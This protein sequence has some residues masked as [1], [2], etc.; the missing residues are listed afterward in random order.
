MNTMSATSNKD[1]NESNGDEGGPTELAKLRQEYSTATLDDTEMSQDPFVV[2]Q[3]WL[4][5]ALRAK[6]HEPNAMCLAT[7]DK[8]TGMP[9]A[10][11]VLLKGF[12]P[13]GGFVWYTNYQSH[14]GMQLEANPQAALCFWWAELE[15][16]VRIEGVVEKVSAEESDEY[17]AKRPP[18]ARLGALASNQ[19]QPIESQQALEQKFQ[20]LQTEYLTEDYELKTDLARPS[21]W[22]GY[23]LKPTMMEFWKG[24]ASRI[25]DRIRYTRTDI[26]AHEGWTRERLQP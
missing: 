2:F 1:K 23:R 21:H 13:E 9:S 7:C 12:S 17:F 6:V 3:E 14:K 25:H 19:S 4:N 20:Y 22:G 8:T 18:Q 16:S 26:D 11:Y 24:R 10:R 5:E 15:R